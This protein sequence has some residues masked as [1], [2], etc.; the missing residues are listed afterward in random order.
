MGFWSSGIFFTLL[1]FVKMD[2]Q[3][4]DMVLSVSMNLS[5]EQADVNQKIVRRLL[6][7]LFFMTIFMSYSLPHFKKNNNSE[8][9]R[10]NEICK[11]AVSCC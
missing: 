11:S 9:L 3:N 6:L 8:T 10:Y 7:I 2:C 4:N 5:S 1:G